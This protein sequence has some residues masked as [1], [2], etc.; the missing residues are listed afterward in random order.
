[1]DIKELDRQISSNRLDRCYFFCGEEQFLMDSKIRAIKKKLISPDF[2]ELNFIRIEGKRIPADEIIEACQNYPVMSDKKMIVVRECGIFNNAKL[3]DFSKLVSE[4]EDLP[5]FLCIIFTEREFDKKKEKNLDVFKKNG[6]IVR[7]DPLPPNQIE[8]WLEKM[9]ENAG[10]R[11][12]SRDLTYMVRLCGTSMSAAYNEYNKLINYLGD[13]VKI[14]K[15]DIDAVVAK[16]VEARVFDM[17]DN[18]AENRGTKVMEELYALK[19]CGENPSAVLTLLNSRFAELLMVKQL[20]AEGLSSAKLAEY[21]EPKRPPFV[22]SKLIGQC[23]KFGEPYLIRMTE[24]GLRYAYE[25]RCGLL[26]KWA[27]VEMYVA[28][29]VKI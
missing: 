9:F 18:V 10:K 21:F 28:E 12:I 15:E 8:L 3:N 26:D 11:I 17:L 7:F 22:V 24:K 5:D 14:T 23:K 27:A 1:M 13:R 19:I 20:S 29:L 6:Q 2:E 4:L 16:T 25:V